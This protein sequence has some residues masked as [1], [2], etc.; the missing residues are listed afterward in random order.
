MTANIEFV[1]SNPVPKSEFLKENVVTEANVTF[2]STTD[3]GVAMHVA[4]TYKSKAGKTGVDM[5]E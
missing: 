2:L 1:K 5:K 3:N 4:Y